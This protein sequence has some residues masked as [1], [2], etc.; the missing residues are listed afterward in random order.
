MSEAGKA[1]DAPAMGRDQGDAAF[2]ETAELPFNMFQGYP[3]ESKVTD[4]GQVEAPDQELS[5]NLFA[6]GTT[7]LPS[8]HSSAAVS[9]EQPSIPG[10]GEPEGVLAVEH[11]AYEEQPAERFEASNSPQGDQPR[12]TVERGEARSLHAELA[13][14]S[15]AELARDYTVDYLSPYEVSRIPV[16]NTCVGGCVQM[17]LRDRGIAV[18]W[19]E[20]VKQYDFQSVKDKDFG[21]V[22]D[23]LEQLGVPNAH[24]VRLRMALEDFKEDIAEGGPAIA[25]MRDTKDKGHA[26]VVDGFR[27]DPH[28]GEMVLIRDPGF[29]PH[30]RTYMMPMDIFLDRWRQRAITF[31]APA[32]NKG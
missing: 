4:L 1:L 26:I 29:F 9:P 30:G 28:F 3:A 31:P 5:G 17:T 25:F 2:S 11:S 8:G 15:W 13:G 12:D 22:R 27:E 14:K 24:L 18:S 32:E 16:E 10:V 19:R 20:L 23:A 6:Y 21:K 7:E